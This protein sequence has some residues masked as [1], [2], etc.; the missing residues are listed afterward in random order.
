M[1]PIPKECE[2]LVTRVRSTY[3]RP[4]SLVEFCQTPLFF[5]VLP[6]LDTDDPCEGCK[7]DEKAMYHWFHKECDGDLGK[8]MGAVWGEEKTK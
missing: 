2:A 6:R 4:K 7:P 8:L 5:P 3:K 1:K